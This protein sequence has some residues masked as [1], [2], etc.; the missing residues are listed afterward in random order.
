MESLSEFINPALAW[1][2]TGLALL[3][4]EFAFPG[5]IIFFFGVGAWVVALVCLA[6]DVSLN[7]Q[8]LIFLI[9]SVVLMLSLRKWV[10]TVFYGKV[11]AAGHTDES[12]EGF[13]GEKVVV[14]KEITPN[15]KG[16][17]EFRGTRWD[18]ESEDTIKEGAPAE[19]TG[20]DNL[21]L[22]VKSLDK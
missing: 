9:V 5:L 8:L 17:V 3:L 19:I 2:L 1:F 14:A 21:T 6:F 20:K 13:V 22:I 4:L 16:R 15:M 11:A 10:K 18:A 7:T 12:M